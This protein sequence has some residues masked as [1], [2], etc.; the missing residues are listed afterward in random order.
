MFIEPTI[1]EGPS[2]DSSMM[3][4]EIFG[5]ILPVLE[6][7]DLGDLIKLINSRPKPLAIYLFSEN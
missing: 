2:L 7:T 1:V 6:Y 4:E 3:T 5:P